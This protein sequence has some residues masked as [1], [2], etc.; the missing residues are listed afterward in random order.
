MSFDQTAK[1]VPSP[2]QQDALDFVEKGCG[3][4]VI[5]AVAGSGKTSFIEMTLPKIPERC[6]VTVLA[7]GKDIAKELN[8][9]LDKLRTETGR[10]FRNF[11]A[12]TFHSVGVGLV[13]RAL[14]CQ[15]RELLI[16][17]KKCRKLFEAHVGADSAAYTMYGDFVTKL[18]G[19]AKGEG[20]GPLTPDT[21]DAWW[22]LVRHHDLT[23]ESEEANEEEAIA[24]AR[25]LL[26]QS[27][28]AS[29]GKFIDYDDM[30]F[31]PLVWR[32]RPFQS[33]WI[34]VDEAQDT[35]PV[36][37]AMAKGMLRPGGRSIWVGDP[38][39]AIY[40][41]TG[42]TSNAID[43]IKH[44][45]N[46]IELPLSVCY[47]CSKAVVRRAQKIVPYI[48]AWDG[49][50]EGSDQ[51]LSEKDAL[52]LL[53][54]SDAILCRNT[55]P[56]I[57]MAYQLISEGRACKVMGRDIGVGLLNLIKRMRAKNIDQLEE[58]LEK[59]R[60]RETAKFMAK[61][62]EQ[63]AERISDHVDCVLCTARNMPEGKRTIVA[64]NK[65]IEALFSDDNGTDILTL[66]TLHKSKG[67]EWTRVAILRPDLMPSPWARQDWQVEQE[68]HLR[69]VGD[70]RA[71]VD[72]ITIIPPEKKARKGG[73]K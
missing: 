49:A 53:E 4:A 42:A 35:S 6:Y 71:R 66:A 3:N 40:G 25:E 21:E 19:F 27:N 20:I 70:T 65:Q 30:L 43:L 52:A 38:K 34:F 45:F 22:S 28:V 39:Q 55:A 60:D 44:Q 26:G 51:T 41:F 23:L 61:G 56:L 72:I 36:R 48:E 33:D 54:A 5:I 8:V 32:L 67:K 47:R 29:K 15:V 9:R 62:E 2:Y 13:A 58:K 73:A 18:V 7:F 12:S 69:Y 37:R 68:D 46:A 59:Y 1:L 31:M 10:P 57:D 50:V 63:K 11:R 16:S 14:K 64:L 24:Y 17:D